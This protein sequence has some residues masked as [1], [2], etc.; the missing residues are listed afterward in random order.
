MI[1]AKEGEYSNKEGLVDCI[2]TLRGFKVLN[3]LHACGI[4]DVP[5]FPSAT[6]ISSPESCTVQ[7]GEER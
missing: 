4:Q 2:K 7:L 5:I 3:R 6:L 1:K